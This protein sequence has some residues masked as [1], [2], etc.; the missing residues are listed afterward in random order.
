MNTKKTIIAALLMGISF[1]THAQ[2]AVITLTGTY[3]DTVIGSTY[4][5]FSFEFEAPLK[6]VP[7]AII[8]SESAFVIPVTFTY[9]N[10]DLTKALTGSAAYFSYPDGYSGLDLRMSNWSGTGDSLQIIVNSPAPLF[11]GSSSDPTLLITEL[12]SRAGFSYYPDD[13]NNVYFGESCHY[14]AVPEPSTLSLI[15]VGIAFGIRKR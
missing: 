5:D 9:T 7:P 6:P 13:N 10:G 11:S 4:T 3:S 14:S 1:F 12:N 15:A 8:E 2:A